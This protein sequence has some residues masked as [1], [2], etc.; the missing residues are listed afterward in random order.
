MSAASSD[1]RYPAVFTREDEIAIVSQARH[2]KTL[3]GVG[4]LAVVL[5]ILNGLGAFDLVGVWFWVSKTL[6]L[7]VIG[8]LG[9]ELFASHSEKLEV[10]WYDARAAAESIK[11]LYWRFLVGGDPFPLRLSNLDA[12]TLLTER[13]K[14]V[15]NELGKAE[16]ESVNII[17]NETLIWA[18]GVREQSLT[19]RIDFY[20]R[21]RIKNQETWY[22]NK[23]RRL[24]KLSKR[25]LRVAI[26][27]AA[28]A[29]LLA[30]GI[31]IGNTIDS[32]ATD[33]LNKLGSFSGVFLQSAVVLFGYSAIRNYRRDSRAYEVTRSEIRAISLLIT[34]N[35][36]ESD[37]AAL[38]DEIE[39]VFSRE[40]VTWH[41]S[42]SG[43]I[44]LPP[45]GS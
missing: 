38:V 9:F 2:R 17:D 19:E 37:W 21:L 25:L 8:L 1:V 23:A 12:E 22:A 26:G 16:S 14:R 15:L 31:L 40:H 36:I 30:V 29:F 39:E 41:A 10:P 3:V 24:D 4:A 20:H 27:A 6:F 35:F 11:T 34:N 43:E 44:K 5:E 42:H 33:I 32:R 13:I 18:L 45:V 7:V 28:I